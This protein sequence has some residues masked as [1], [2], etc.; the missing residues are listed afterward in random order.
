MSL[1][2]VHLQVPKMPDRTRVEAKEIRLSDM[3]PVTLDD[4]NMHTVSLP[5]QIAYFD[6]CCCCEHL[7]LLNRASQFSSA[8]NNCIYLYIYPKWVF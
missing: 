6:I 3:P 7:L 2:C 1:L 4:S 5:L 8:L